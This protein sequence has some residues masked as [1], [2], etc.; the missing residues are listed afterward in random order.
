MDKLRAAAL[1]VLLTAGTFANAISLPVVNPGFEDTAGSAANFNEFTFGAF[2]GWEI[3]DDP[4]GLI[5]NGASNPFYVGTLT[6]QPDSNN[7][8]DFVYF[9][10]GA[11]EGQRVAIAFNRAGSDDQGEY[12]LQQTLVGIPLLANRRYTLQVEIGNIAS[13][14]AVSGE[15]FILDGFPGYRVDLLV[16]GQPVASDDNSLGGLILDGEWATSIVIFSTD[17][18]TLGLGSD[19]GI[20]LVNLNEIDPAYPGSDLEVDFDDVRLDVVPAV[21]GDFN[22]DGTVNAA[23]YTVWR[24]DLDGEF[25]AS[26]YNTWANNYGA[27]ISSTSEAVSVPEP[28]AVA[29]LVG[30]VLLGTTKGY[31]R[32]N[33]G[34]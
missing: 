24:D 15:N 3:Y 9:P 28:S 33:L 7:P 13:G 19:L 30:L 17:D 29:L 27:S 5:G 26:D 6:P 21:D 12:G 25:V 16:G 31:K 10:D 4:N 32:V 1:F 20:R 34:A 11:P 22:F 8:G 2:L 23:D 14:I 18:L